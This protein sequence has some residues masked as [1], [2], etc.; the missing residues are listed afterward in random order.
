M[1]LDSATRAGMF[2]RQPA[3][4]TA[5]VPA[6]FPPD[7]LDLTRLQELMERATLALGRLVG[8]A[9]I[10]PDPDLFVY[11][12]VR[13]EA[14]L[15]SQMEGTEASLVDLLEYEAEMEKADRRVDVRE[16]TNYIAALRYGLERVQELPLSLR[17]IGEIHERLM[18][19]VRGGEA[20]KTPSEFRRS[21]NWI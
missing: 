9:E 20:A 19:G 13:R 16:I 12:Y 11:M 15:S 3:G 17:L 21:Q 6:P 4:H 14:V 10:L 2:R 7:D 18:T 5:F 8:A 1:K